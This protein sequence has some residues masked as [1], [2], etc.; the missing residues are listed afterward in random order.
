MDIFFRPMKT[1]FAFSRLTEDRFG[2]GTSRK[3]S[4]DVD[5]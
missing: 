2:P 5:F 3:V 4:R 1:Q